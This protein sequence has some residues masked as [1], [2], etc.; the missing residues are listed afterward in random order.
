MSEMDKVYLGDGCYVSFDGY[1]LELTTSN[2]IKITN[3][4][5]LEPEIWDALNRFVARLKEST[6]KVE[7][8]GE[9]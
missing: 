1:A 2:G 7:S 6:E 9:R 3:R 4:I 8:E 5:F